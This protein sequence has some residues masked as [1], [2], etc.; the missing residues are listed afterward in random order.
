[1]TRLQMTLQDFMLEFYAKKIEILQELLADKESATM[2]LRYAEDNLDELEDYDDLESYQENDYD[3]W[4]S[5]LETYEQFKADI[6]SDFK[7]KDSDIQTFLEIARVK[8]GY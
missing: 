7:L 4:A 8:E 6:R 2:N 5:Y 1:M 3:C